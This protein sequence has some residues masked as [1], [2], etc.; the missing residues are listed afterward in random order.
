MLLFSSGVACA[1]PPPATV[2]GM[3][4][5]IELAALSPDGRRLAIAQTQDDR[6]FIVVVDLAG[7]GRQV[8]LAEPENM[9]VQW[10][11][12]AS[13]DRI[14]CGFS[15]T[16]RDARTQMTYGL[17]RMIG[18]NADGSGTR[19]LVQNSQAATGQFQDRVIAWR[20]GKPNT[21]LL[22]ADKG[23]DSH[24][25]TSNASVIGSNGTYAQPAVWELD[26]VNDRVRLRQR[27]R[28][29]IYAWLA[30]SRG[31]VRVGYGLEGDTFSVFGR[32]AG[33]DEWRVLNKFRAFS[34]DHSL[35]PVAISDTEPDKAYAI[36]NHEGYEAVWLVDL[37][38][39]QAPRVVHAEPGVDIE[40]AVFGS[41]DR[42]IGFYYERVG[43][44]IHYLDGRARAVANGVSK[45]M[46]GQFV[47]VEGSSDDGA[48]YLLQ[49]GDDVNPR[50]YSVFERA[51]GTVALAGEPYPGLDRSQL[52]AAQPITYP[53]RDGTPIPGYLTLPHE[54][55]RNV[56]LVVMPHGGPISRDVLGFDFL[57]QFLVSRGYAVLQMNFRGSGGYG[58]AWQYAAHQDWGGLTYDDVIDG[59][60]WAIKEGYADPRRACVVGWSFGGYVALLGAQR[61]PDLFRCAVS[62]AGV[63]DLGMLVDSSSHYVGSSV[64]KAQVGEDDETLDRNSPRLHAAEFGA[65]VLL[66]HGD[67]DPI[68][69]EKH[70]VAMATALKRAGKPYKY[71]VLPGADHSVRLGRDRSLLLTEIEQF[72]AA[73]TAPAS[74]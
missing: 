35:V 26:V 68:V 49:A 13:N 55:A 30:D 60:R 23:L 56:P 22:A 8:A 14:V 31:D 41:D 27:P 73:N 59:T 52:R 50:T 33:D 21:V 1:A 18:V 74:H 66:L 45:A 15:G 36:G 24:D 58:S 34:G 67:R 39:E 4:P 63:S 28:P 32:I 37:K 12:W 48:K 47:S 53:A 6:A 69:Q 65:P 9:L 57:R 38:D 70:S 29:P 17:T 11:R 72:L 61:N 64:I 2:F 44:E 71:V 51:T 3:R 54:G 7:S 20:T 19:V 5:R 40:S 25:T 62:I 10:C 46:K 42:L 16:D 43:P